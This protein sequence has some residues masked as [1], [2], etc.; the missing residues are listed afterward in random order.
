VEK[1]LKAL[2]IEQQAT[3][4]PRT[5]DLE[6]LGRQ[7]GAPPP[8]TTDLQLLNPAFDLVRY[9]DSTGGSAPVDAVTPA[10]AADHMAAAERVLTWIEPQ[11]SPPSSHP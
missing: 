8:V 3:L 9:P 2:Y 1:G 7:T 6:Y 11:L 4:A 10:L 5:H